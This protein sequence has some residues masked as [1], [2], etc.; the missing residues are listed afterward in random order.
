M[1][2]ARFGKICVTAHEKNLPSSG[3]DATYRRNASIN[4]STVMPASRMRARRS[5]VFNSPWSGTVSGTRALVG[6]RSRK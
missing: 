4:S 1:R 3:P 2:W 5:P 6:C